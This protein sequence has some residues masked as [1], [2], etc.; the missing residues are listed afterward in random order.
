MLISIIL[1]VFTL[2]VVITTIYSMLMLIGSSV[3]DVDAIKQSKKPQF[4]TK[5]KIKRYRPLVSIVIPVFNEEIGINRCLNGLNK[6]RY[7]KV[8]IIVADDKSTDQTRQI[9]RAYIKNHPDRNIRL[10]CKRKNGGRGAA[11]NLGAK[12]AKGEIVIAFDADCIFDKHSIHRLVAHFADDRVAAVAA[13]VR[14]MDNGTVL[15]MLEKLEYLISFRSKKFNTITNSEYII[16]GAGASY[17]K[18]ILDKEGGFDESMKTEDIEFSM[19]IAKNNGTKAKL[20]YA[21]DYLVHTEPVPTYQGLFRQ[22]YRWKFGSLQALYKNR[23]LVISS[24]HS[25]NKFMGWVR[26]PLAIWSEVMLL[27]EPILFGLFV[28][29]AVVGKNPWLFISA[30]LAYAIVTWLAIWSDEHYSTSTRLKLSFLAPFMYVASLVI[31]VIQVVAA[32]KC[33][34]NFMTITGRVKV[35]GTYISTERFR[36]SLEVSV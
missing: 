28:Y 15:S 4:V 12:H 11:I 8:E 32:F 35:D 10:V 26:L 34:A 20:I 18:L 24:N 3:Y 25:Q 14:V 19:R 13:N 27:L 5:T 21:S 17:R 2:T 6:L 22:R 29:I 23:A 31:S 30:S 9:I 33:L 1:V 16:G 36:N 7:R